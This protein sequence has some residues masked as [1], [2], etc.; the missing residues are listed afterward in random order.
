MVNKSGTSDNGKF[1]S[2]K[3]NSMLEDLNTIETDIMGIP[4]SAIKSLQRGYISYGVGDMLDKTIMLSVIDAS[5]AICIIDNNYSYHFLSN[6]S[7]HIST[8]IY[9]VLYND[10]VVIT[11]IPKRS[12][13]YHIYIGVTVIEFY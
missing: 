11:S 13:G 5:R 2:E 8:N 7:N 1:L 9:S 10:K 6:S 4:K 3:L 12:K